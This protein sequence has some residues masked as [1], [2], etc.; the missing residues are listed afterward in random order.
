MSPEEF[1]EAVRLLAVDNAAA[2]TVKVLRQPPGRRPWPVDVR[3]SEW[4]N[5]LA[6]GDQSFVEE[7]VKAA[8]FQSAFTFCSILDGITAFDNEHGTLRLVYVAPDG[9]ESVLND[10]ARCELHAE[11]RGDG[12]PP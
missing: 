6:Q 9:S 10:A 7:V 3:R 4:F 2:G 12:P 11:L 8:A 1:V 5:S